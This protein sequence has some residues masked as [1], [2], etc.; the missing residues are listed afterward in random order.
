[1]A[2][3]KHK[4]PWDPLT[5]RQTPGDG[6]IYYGPT[7]KKA[8][9]VVASIVDEATEEILEMKKWFSE[10]LD[11]R[12]N[13]FVNKE[14]MA[15]LREH[16]VSGVGMVD[17]ILGCPHEEGIDYPEGETCPQC[18]YWAGRDRFTDEPID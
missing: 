5:G 17:R 6:V 15:F 3:K 9:K 14:I 1:M 7:A 16:A 13:Q 12:R 18:P 4:F 11:I 10:T 8:S 2:L